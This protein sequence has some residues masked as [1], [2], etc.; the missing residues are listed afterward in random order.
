MRQTEVQDLGLTTIR[1]EN[2]RGLDVAVH[3][4]LRVCRLQPVG[5]LNPQ[6]QHF[7]RLEQFP[8][9]ELLQGLPLQALHGDEGF[10]LV[11]SDLVNRA[12][13]RVVERRRRPR[14]A[15]EPFQELAVL[16]QCVGQELERYAPPQLGIFSFVNDTHAAATQLLQDPVV[17][18]SRAD[19]SRLPC[20][21]AMLAH[22]YGHVNSPASAALAARRWSNVQ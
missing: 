9:Q 8:A 14:L 5:N 16:G 2:V 1:H 21:E 20:I 6:L 15:A 22:R 3:D 10:A 11:L 7:L 19:H 18:N 13:I 17:R 12:D 4:A